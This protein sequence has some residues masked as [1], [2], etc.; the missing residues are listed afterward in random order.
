MQ[1]EWN[2]HSKKK[3]FREEDFFKRVVLAGQQNI[4]RDTEQI[5]SNQGEVGGDN[6]GKG[7]R[8]FRSIY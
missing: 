6:G 3:C 8:G 2:V 4:I 1:G 5:D 7:G